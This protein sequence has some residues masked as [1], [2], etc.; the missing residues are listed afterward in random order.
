MTDTGYKI[1]QCLNCGYVYDE[2]AGDPDEGFAPGT[3]W[4]DIPDD[5]MCPQCGTGK[6]EFEMVAI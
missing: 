4:A 5:W 6:S 1:W 3:R 2:E